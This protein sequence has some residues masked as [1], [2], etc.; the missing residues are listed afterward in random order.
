VHGTKPIEYVNM[1]DNYYIK[2]SL[3]FT[4]KRNKNLFLSH[5][6]DVTGDTELQDWAYELAHECFGWQDGNTRGMPE[7]IST[8]D[9]LVQS[10]LLIIVCINR[11]DSFQFM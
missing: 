7:K 3:A 9:Q 8:V 11:T 5:S 6:Q 1:R 2:Y 10:L 4:I